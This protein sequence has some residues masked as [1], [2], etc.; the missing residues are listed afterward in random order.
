MFA[1]RQA[2][3]TAGQ[4]TRQG[5]NQGAEDVLAVISQSRSTN[6]RGYTVTIHNDGGATAE[7]EGATV[8]GHAGS[9]RS[10]QFPA[11]TVDTK[12]LR[13]L[14][15]EIGDVGKIPTGGCAKSVSFGTSTEITYAGKTSGDLQ[16]IR[17]DVSEGG[18]APLQAS[19]NLGKFV[20]TTLGQLKIDARRNVW[21]ARPGAQ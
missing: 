14:L 5:V 15:S 3:A 7:I 19:Q 8:V 10:Q 2:A 6:S 12:T 4:E 18:E 1:E 11:G 16:C 13:N 17:Q 21:T 20:Q 9:P